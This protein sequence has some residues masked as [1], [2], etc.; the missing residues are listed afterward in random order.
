MKNQFPLL[1]HT[2]RRFIKKG[3][4]FTFTQNPFNFSLNNVKEMIWKAE[5]NTICKC[6]SITCT[7]MT[8]RLMSLIFT[9]PRI[10]QYVWRQDKRSVQIITREEVIEQKALNILKWEHGKLISASFNFSILKLSAMLWCYQ[11]QM[12]HDG[13]S[14]CIFIFYY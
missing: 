5:N 14:D 6:K 13:K 1:F 10:N 7:V 11:K 9:L 3:L 2:K 8:L 12:F 4:N